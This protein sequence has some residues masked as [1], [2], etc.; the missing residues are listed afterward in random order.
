MNRDCTQ[1][2]V[3]LAD[4]LV[5]AR[6]RDA[7]V[8]QNNSQGSPVD[9]PPTGSI[10]SSAYEQL[11]NA[12]EYSEEHLLLQ[13]AIKRFCKLNLFVTG[14]KSQQIG[15]ELLVELVHAGYLQ[16][17]VAT[18]TVVQRIDHVIETHM[19]LY[20]RLREAR[21]GRDLAMDW[22]LSFISVEAAYNL[23]PN[24]LQRATVLLG[25][26]HFMGAL[27][28]D[29]FLDME[30][31]NNYELCV[32]VAVHQAIMKSD[33]DTVRRELF[34]LYKSPM[35]SVLEFR[36]FNEQVDRIFQSA[37]TARLRRIISRNGAPFRILK[38]LVEA[39]HNLADVVRQPDVFLE[40]YRSQI[41]K[42]YSAV[43]RR[44]NRGLIKSIAFLLIS[45]ALIGLA[46]EIPYDLIVYGGI[47]WLPLAVNLLFPA[48]YMAALKIGL[49]SPSSTNAHKLQSYIES[50]LYGRADMKVIVPPKK[51]IG[52][53]A[54]VA[55][56]VIF[57]VP[58]VLSVLILRA[59]G[60]NIVQMAIFFVFFS[61]ATSLGFRLSA[62]I[63]DLEVIG[64]RTGFFASV[65]EFFY[66]P[67]IVTGQWISRKYSKVNFVARFLDVAI[68]LP[69]KATLRLIRQWIGFL[70]EKREELY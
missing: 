37:L 47:V 25:Y 36:D 53:F 68:E 35:N 8:L 63:R 16:S 60:F 45:K 4:Q 12:A 59:I 41:K 32:F 69:L 66:L 58:I 57:L 62:M 28:R 46:I 30:D 48:L 17:N 1:L 9:I 43:H 61:T 13:R 39:Q 3:I 56:A 40:L 38:S 23:S 22:I 24:S 15:R 55:Y 7:L 42:E 49:K 34:G 18:S 31:S 19:Q 44:L 10:L 54:R 26:S 64:H 29:L 50:L 20:E 2:C 14:Y 5:A 70:N 33:I 51:R 27:N 21:V 11:R 52:N 6:Q 65:H 67:F